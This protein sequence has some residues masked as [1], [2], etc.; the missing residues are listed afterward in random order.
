ELSKK[1]IER[2]DTITVRDIIIEAENNFD[3]KQFYYIIA[4][5]LNKNA[6]TIFENI[7]NYIS[8]LYVK[9]ILP[10]FELSAEKIISSIPAQKFLKSKS[11]DYFSVI[12][13]KELNNLFTEDNFDTFVK[14]TANYLKDKFIEKESS[15]KK[16]LIDRIRDIEIDK[17]YLKN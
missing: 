12:L 4:N 5:F 1:I 15:I 13:S 8:K 11:K 7:E 9:D 17:N 3:I 14:R 16:F 10:K 6:A 2:L